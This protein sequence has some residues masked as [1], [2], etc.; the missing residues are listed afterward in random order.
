MSP[1]N[2]RLNDRLPKTSDAIE[3]SKCPFCG[4]DAKVQ[5]EKLLVRVECTGCFIR[6]AR[7][8]SVVLAVGTWNTRVN[9]GT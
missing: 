3:L 2:E 7:L 6:T 4:G 9:K 8:P 5:E 1:F